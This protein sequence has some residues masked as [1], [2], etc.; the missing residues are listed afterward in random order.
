M[1]GCEE[2]EYGHTSEEW[3]KRIHPEDLEPVQREI[4]T[5]LQKGSTQFEIQHRMLHQD[6]CY[7]WMSCRGVIKRDDSGRAVRIT[8][9]HLDITAEKVVDALTGLPNRLLLLER[10]TRSIERAIK[11]KDF[12]FAVLTLDL[13]LFESGAN[14]LETVNGDSLV[15]AAARRLETALKTDSLAREGREYLVTRSGGEE[16][17]I[18]LEGL[19]E[20]SE[21]KRVA[22]RLLKEVLVPFEFNGRGLHLTPSVGIALS[23]SGYQ[24]AEEALRDADT[25]LHRAKSLGK[26]RC[27]VFDTATLESALILQ[28]LEKDLEGSLIR[29]ELLVY[30]QPILSLSSNRIA[31][32]EAL[33]RW[34]HPS[35]GMVSPAEFI[36]IA[37]KTG[38]IIPLGR[39]VLQRAC[40]QLKAWQKNPLVSQNLWVSVNLSIAQFLQPSLVEE[41]RDALLEAG[42]DASCLILELTEGTVM[43]NPDKIRSLLMQLRVMGAK[44]GLDDFG[45]GYSSLAHLRQLPLD[46]LKID[47]SFARSI[48]TSSDAREIVRA[49]ITLAQQLGLHTVAEGIENSSQLEAVRSLNCEYAQGFLFS[50]PVPDEKAEGLLLSSDPS[51]H[52]VS[53]SSVPD[54][55]QDQG[56][57]SI[58]P[59]KVKWGLV[60]LT[61]LILL[62]VGGLL[63]RM[64]RS[65]SSTVV[66]P[67][68]EES[69]KA[70]AAPQIAETLPARENKEAAALEASVK[71]PVVPSKAASTTASERIYKYPVVH[72][73]TLGNCKG[74]MKIARDGISFDSEKDKDSF[75]LKYSE[76]SFFLR[77]DQLTIDTGSKIYRFKSAT[78][79]TEDEN[80]SNLLKI[81][82][83]ISRFH[84]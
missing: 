65:N 39:W 22:D 15:I 36:P 33:V 50:K 83:S 76:F 45:T 47:R 3:F 44:I 24:N 80:K 20:V 74:V 27:E 6:G 12:L 60:G 7:R 35:R 82:R 16:F 23:A 5:Q 66:P 46:F 14:R 49:I 84:L 2:S 53:T 4:N 63:A 42:L 61:A 28:Q 18:L 71:P 40:R 9:C 55:G 51:L 48:E 78:A 64:N 1:L 72:D 52:Q 11:Q 57:R 70:P 17:I 37:E 58:V 59:Q 77:R 26:S 8:G 34:N 41:I 81:Y 56:K 19:S 43:K 38:F 25:A 13:D 79:K 75:D 32:F 21:A 54:L 10:L 67:K 30:Y 31:G 29:N 73:H 68:T 69:I 62:I